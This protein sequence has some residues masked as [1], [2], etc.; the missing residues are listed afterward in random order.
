MSLPREAEQ[1]Y[2][3]TSSSGA[4][5]AAKPDELWQNYGQF[6]VSYQKTTLQCCDQGQRLGVRLPAN[7]IAA[8]MCWSPSS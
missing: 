7:T 3:T 1:S 5:T 2:E 8:T 4:E 6:F